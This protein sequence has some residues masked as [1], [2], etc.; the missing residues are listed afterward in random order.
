MLATD[1]KLLLEKRLLSLLDVGD[2]V[3]KRAAIYSTMA[4]S[5]RIRPLIVLSI[6][7]EKALDA[8]C[9]IEML[10]TYS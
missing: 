4:P 5:K 6:A 1:Y 7:D 2:P 10:H 8:A 9:A 3:L